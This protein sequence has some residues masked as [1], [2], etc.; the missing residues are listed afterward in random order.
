MSWSNS[1]DITTYKS[2]H[3]SSHELTK[4]IHP[5]FFMFRFPC[6]SRYL[7]VARRIKVL[8]NYLL[9]NYAFNYVSIC[10]LL[11]SFG[12]SLATQ[13]RTLV[14]E[15]NYILKKKKLPELKSYFAIE[16]LHF[17][18]GLGYLNHNIWLSCWLDCRLVFLQALMLWFEEG[19]WHSIYWSIC[20]SWWPICIDGN[21]RKDNFLAL[22]ILKKF[23]F[24]Y[25]IC[26]WLN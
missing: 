16:F 22:L 4:W 9:K 19:L 14:L 26:I 21:F 6:L 3:R 17:H 12:Y 15:K 1:S 20:P 23:K 13:A 5:F 18:H 10:F 2:W 25:Y 11:L 24:S 7:V 8:N